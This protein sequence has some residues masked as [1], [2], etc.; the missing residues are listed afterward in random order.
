ME[1]MIQNEV[2]ANAAEVANNAAE[3]AVKKVAKSTGEKWRQQRR[4]TYGSWTTSDTL[5]NPQKAI[6]WIDKQLKAHAT[7]VA[8]LKALRKEKLKELFAEL[9]EE[10]KATING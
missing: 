8:N 5:D 4:N 1:E 2:V 3:N 6:I 7:Q 10:D 9:S